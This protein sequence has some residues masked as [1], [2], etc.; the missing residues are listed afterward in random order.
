MGCHCA[1]DSIDSNPEEE[2]LMA[3][4]EATLGFSR[5]S[6]SHL[7]T[8]VLVLT[9]NQALNTNRLKR[10]GKEL[11]V[12]LS[13]ILEGGKDP[14][15]HFY[16]G[17]KTSEETWESR[18]LLILALLLGEGSI[19]AKADC[20]FSLFD[21]EYNKYLTSE[22]LDN[23]LEEVCKVALDVLPT[24]CVEYLEHVGDLDGAVL[25]QNYWEKLKATRSEA[26]YSLKSLIL[27][28]HED[29]VTLPTF[30]TKLMAQEPDLLSARGLRRRAL[31]HYKQ[32]MRS[33]ARHRPS[34]RLVQV[35]Q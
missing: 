30:K 28:P 29:Q 10:L 8:R 27:D 32:L 7:F 11:K 9:V 5:Q 4:C 31:Q 2:V 24:Y 25:V 23:M 3:R 1:H 35:S 26:K 34:A 6:F 15:S 21:L 16:A 18:K 20:L 14:V 33:Q 12:D 19:S 13:G 22:E 17:L